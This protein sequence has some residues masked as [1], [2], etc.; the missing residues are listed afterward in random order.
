MNED[1][2][3]ASRTVSEM[4]MAAAEERRGPDRPLASHEQVK[5]VERVINELIDLVQRMPNPHFG[6]G[7]HSALGSAAQRA[8]RDNAIGQI[9]DTFHFGVPDPRR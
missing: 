2:Q 5:R 4:G 6:L 8:M 3:R 9:F 1:F 7:G